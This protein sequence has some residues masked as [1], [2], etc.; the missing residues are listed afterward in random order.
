MRA[1]VMNDQIA[2]TVAEHEYKER[3]KQEAQEEIDVK[4]KEEEEKKEEKKEKK[5]NY[6]YLQM[7]RSS[8]IKYKSPYRPGAQLERFQYTNSHRRA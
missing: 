7:T 8:N 3:L 6:S 2:Y 1:R 4:K 5:L